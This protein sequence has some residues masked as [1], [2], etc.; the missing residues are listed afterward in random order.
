VLVGA[1]PSQNPA[2]G[3]ADLSN[4]E[5]EQIHLAASIQPHGALLLVTE[6]ALR[7]VQSSETAAAFLGLSEPL[8]GRR[9]AEIDA[10]LAACVGSHI[11]VRSETPVAARCSLTTTGVAYDCLIHRPVGGGLVVEL[12]R[13][14]PVIDL[15]RHVGKALQTIVG[16]SSVAMLCDETAR[17]FRDLTGYDRVMVYRFDDTGHGE[18]FSEQRRADLEPYLGNHYP[19]SDIP[20]NA[21]R[22]YERNRVRV[23]V[24]VA[25]TPVPLV[26]K[27]SPI[28]AA[29]LDMSL[30]FLRSMSPLHTQYLSNMGVA[31]TLVASL[32]VGGR[33]WGLVA[34]HHNEPRF[35]QFEVRA[36]CELLAEAVAT[37]IAALESFVQAQAELSVR[38][39]EQRM[40]EAISREGDWRASLFDT[41]QPLLQPLGAS[42]AALIL[43]D[44]VLTS[45]D[46]PATQQIRAIG[47]WL[48]S[49]SGGP[50]LATSALEEE[51]PE[52]AHLSPDV[53]GLLATPVS[54]S[55]GDYLIWFRPERVRTLVWGGNPFKPVIVGNDPRELSP[56]RSFAQWHQLVEGTSE[57]WTQADRTTARLIGETVADVILQFRAVQMLIVEDQLSQIGRQVHGSAQPV[58]IADAH[59]KLLLRN[60]AFDRLLPAR[61]ERPVKL[62]DL[63][64]LF[65]EPDSIAQNLQDLLRQRH[66]WRS[67]VRLETDWG[68]IRPFVVRADPVFAFPKRLIGFVLLLM[69]N[70]EREAAD[71]ARRRFQDGLVEQHQFG[72]M[73]LDSEAD[74]LFRN[75]LSAMLENAQIAALEI[76][77]GLDLARMPQMLESV[78]NSV[79]RASQVLEHLVRHASEDGAPDGK[80]G[81]D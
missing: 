54:N 20:Q 38:R 39:L 56:R 50:I 40:V 68:D 28:T 42:G 41:S 51:V 76:T 24:D 10:A 46:V 26:P 25:Y 12:E 49:Q 70:T 81:R 15:S 71:H 61:R 19:A 62:A 47:A 37:R 57:P 31:A 16:T 43:D 75:L 73:H 32:M 80:T 67:E 48:Q 78:R 52:L 44:Q 74:L 18:I 8:L 55:P 53:S 27:L 9:L 23:L 36:V 5:R 11:P 34:C 65:L 3:E 63:A 14:G 30:C 59:G 29:D 66:P 4:C 21:R 79:A 1:R 2:F 22:L 45:G 6:P 69:D 33:L 77:D 35:A 60:D 17:I 72:V 13:A 64:G 58:V 7:V